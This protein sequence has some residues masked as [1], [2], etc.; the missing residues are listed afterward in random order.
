MN[1]RYIERHNLR[2]KIYFERK[3]KK[4]MVPASSRYLERQ[5][6]ALLRFAGANGTEQ[7]LEVGC[8]MGR[9]TFI[10]AQ[11][12]LKIEVLDLSYGFLYKSAGQSRPETVSV[13]SD[14]V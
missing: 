7:V 11:K 1:E 6:E 3:I 5:T 13:T 4:T 10:L 12:K 2:Q 14:K 8:G 9:Y